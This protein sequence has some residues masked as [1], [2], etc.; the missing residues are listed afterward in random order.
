MK[1]GSFPLFNEAQV[2]VDVADLTTD[3]RQ[4]I[5]YNHLRHGRQP[6]SFLERLQPNL[7]AAARHPGFT[8]E[9]A[10]RLG[11]PAFTG[12]VMPGVPESLASFFGRPSEFLR[13][14]MAGLDTDA[15][16]ALG[17]IFVNHDWLPSPIIPSTQDE[18]LLARLGSTL[19]GVTTS[20]EALRSSL[21]QH[22]VR[23]GAS[24][25]V[26]AHP[27]MVDAYADLLRSPEL[28]HHLLTGFPLTV[29]L[30]EVTCGD[31][32][33]Q[34][35]VIVPATNF[36]MVLDRLEEPLPKGDEAWRAR[37]RRTSFLSTRCDKQ[38]LQMWLD[39]D[40]A[41]LNRLAEPGL[42]L[43]GDPDNELVARL[44]EF[45]LF[46]EVMRST[47]AAALIHYC[48]TGVDPAVLWN[49][50]LASILSEAERASLLARARSE[51]LTDLP[52]AIS[53]C[54][55]DWHRPNGPE[56]AVEPLRELVYHLPKTFPDDAA[57]AAAAKE[58]DRLLD[59]WV[60]EQEWEDPDESRSSRPST[61]A[62]TGSGLTAPQDRS[63]FDD[64][65]DG[66]DGDG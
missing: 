31:V 2:V 35:A 17:L 49:E 38:F 66:R 26:F 12:R 60:A 27:T 44:N 57:V 56:S 7:E 11:D 15:R 53:G 41:R 62:A 37:D 10:R 19:G 47:F 32:G 21:V 34:G 65:M 18:D 39:R 55:D 6:N 36:S 20:L 59:D 46:P 28:L 64:L 5:L 43:E 22:I 30:S 54:T 45:G 40:P 24:G 42:M 63:V 8:P 33:V 52:R 61:P 14:V 29:L 25:W 1:P 16:A 58:L 13:D 3:E 23:N 51:L 9:L 48:I 50:R 4:Q